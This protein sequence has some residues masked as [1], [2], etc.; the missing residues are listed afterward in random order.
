EQG[1]PGLLFFV[2]LCFTALL[3]AEQAYHR[4]VNALRKSWIMTTVLS[5]SIIMITLII[6]DLI[7]TDKIGSFFF[8]LLALLVNFDLDREKVTA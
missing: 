2:L 4:C 8:I 5:F 3:K 6:N 7:E 1:I